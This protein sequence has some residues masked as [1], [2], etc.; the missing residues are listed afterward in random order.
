MGWKVV[1]SVRSQRDIQK[2]V[3]T[4]ARDDPAA[5]KRFGFELIAKAKFV[6]NAPEMGVAM[7]ARP[8]ARLFPCG[9]Y[10]IIYRLDRK[11]QTVRILRFWNGARGKRPLR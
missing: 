1:L 2:I 5:A 3:G 4:I 6:A 8:G 11:R 9:S 10:L 7:P